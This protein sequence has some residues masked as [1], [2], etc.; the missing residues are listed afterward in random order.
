ML[1]TVPP[2]P[3]ERPWN[4]RPVPTHGPRWRTDWL[5]PLL[6]L[7]A[8]PS[9]NPV[10]LLTPHGFV[11]F[12]MILNFRDLSRRPTLSTKAL[13]CYRRIA[14]GDVG[15][16]S[17]PTASSANGSAVDRVKAWR[18]NHDNARRSRRLA[19]PG[20]RNL[21]DSRL[22]HSIRRPNACVQ[23]RGAGRPVRCNAMLCRFPTLVSCNVRY[24]ASATETHH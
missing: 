5:G 19:V 14:G 17:T 8:M 21:N 11:C 1:P 2:R 15:D 23:R 7:A 9:L 13:D 16:G 20:D 22:F 18:R 6:W 3:K 4:R 10:S 12:R 24:A